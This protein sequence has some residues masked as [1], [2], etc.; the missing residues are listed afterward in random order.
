MDIL[1]SG[2]I[3]RALAPYADEFP[4]TVVFAQGLSNSRNAT[5]AEWSREG[6]ALTVALM[7]CADQ[8]KRIVYFSS[9]MVYGDSA[10]PWREDNDNGH[11][12]MPYAQ[13]KKMCE[14]ELQSMSI[15]FGVPY[16]VLRLGNLVGERQNPAQ[17]IPAL[18]AQVRAGH[19]TVQNNAT[20][21]LMDVEDMAHIVVDLLRTSTGQSEILNVAS[22]QS[23][24]VSM[25]VDVLCRVLG[26]Y[27]D[28]HM[29][30]DAGDRQQFDISRLKER[31]PHIWFDSAYPFR[32]L[33]KYV[34]AET[35]EPAP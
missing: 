1:G 3:A 27:A 13:H 24:R 26:R 21:D 22:G 28:T 35:L 4:D 32:A 23:V 9:G 14:L 19:V 6:Q 11:R 2:M 15:H 8:G 33:E 34:H 20:R 17:L 10:L 18:V 25:I 29:V 5:M 7:Q 16:L 31:L 12:R 30:V